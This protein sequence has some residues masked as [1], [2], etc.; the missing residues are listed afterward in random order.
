M[1]VYFK[2]I[3]VKRFFLHLASIAAFVMLSSAVVY[4]SGG[5]EEAHEGNNWIDFAWRTLNFVILAGFLYWL[6]GN[7]I[8]EFFVGRSA[9]IKTSLAE[10]IAAKEEAEMKYK[11]LSD[12]LDKATGEITDIS[13]MIK[14][15]GLAEK[16]RII[17]D[18]K[19]AADKLKEDAQ[20]RV[21]Q[22]FN[23]ASNQ[24]RAEAVAL[25]LQIAEDI[26]KKNVTIE[27]HENMVRDYLDKVVIKH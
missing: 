10:A 7:K 9:D 4:A 19:K 23:K 18:A 17:E 13:D 6:V 27:D 15:Q 26:L 3:P 5:G 14:A 20:R 22:E 8:K 1:N 16:E 24:L 2:N 11:E 21:E 25:S 12:K